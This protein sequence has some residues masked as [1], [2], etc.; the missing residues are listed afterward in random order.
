MN[1]PAT[2]L[3]STLF[4]LTLFVMGSSMAQEDSADPNQEYHQV[5]D[6]INAT[7]HPYVNYNLNHFTAGEN[8]VTFNQYYQDFDRMIRYGIGKMNIIHFGG[9]HIQAD[10]WSNL[11]RERLQSI[12][13]NVQGARGLLFPFKAAKTN[14]PYSYSVDWTGEWE[15]QRSSYNKHQGTWGASGITATTSDS[16]ASMKFTFHQSPIPVKTKSF[17]LLTNIERNSYELEVIAED[18]NYAQIFHEPNGYTRVEYGFEVD[19]IEIIFRKPKDSPDELQFYGLVSDNYRPGLTYH[20]I[21]VNG[22]RFV[23]FQRCELFEEQLPFLKPD[24]VILSIGTNDSSEPDYDSTTYQSNFRLFLEQIRRVN[25]DCAIMLTVPNDNY[26][27]RKYHNDNLESVR[28]V[29]YELAEEFDAKVWDLY[30]IMG[31]AGSAKTWKEAGM[32]KAD[33]VHFTKDGYLLK[34]DLFYQ[35]FLEDYLK[36]YNEQQPIWTE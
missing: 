2:F 10:I 7:K 25:P 15:G 13:T 12:D 32:M 6:S 36:W 20:S 3:K 24:L 17:T 19:S 33:L 30:G 26:V 18:D 31:G 34:G 27:R 4:L 22:S 11:L 8:S 35:A 23:S 29:I 5:T 28:N 16:L 21:G 14:R 1:L 9:S